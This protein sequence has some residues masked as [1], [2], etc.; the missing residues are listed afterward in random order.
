MSEQTYRFYRDENGTAISN[1]PHRRV[2]HSPDGY[3]WGYGG[4]GPADLALNITID[5]LLRLG[6][7]DNGL[8]YTIHQSVKRHFI[9]NMPHEGTEIPCSVFDNYV[10]KEWDILQR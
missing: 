4:S 9:A 1:V 6:I 2:H 7:D 10:S 8:A 3:E 5:C